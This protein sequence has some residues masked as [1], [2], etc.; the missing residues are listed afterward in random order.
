[1]TEKNA[2]T[3][4]SFNNWI[5]EVAEEAGVWVDHTESG[6]FLVVNEE[7]GYRVA[8]ATLSE[9]IR[10][11]D[12]SGLLGRGLVEELSETFGFLVFRIR[13]D[14][15]HNERNVQNTSVRANPLQ[16]KYNYHVGEVKT[17]NNPQQPIG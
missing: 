9:L 16:L 11:I 12:A 17:P 3:V 4:D 5:V 6:Y 2:L 13:A 8:A 10:N 15:K 1:M 7:A 14:Q